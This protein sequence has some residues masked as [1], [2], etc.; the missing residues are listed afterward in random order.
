MSPLRKNIW[1]G[2]CAAALLLIGFMLG[3]RSQSGR[4]DGDLLSQVS[5]QGQAFEDHQ[6]LVK[7]RLEKTALENGIKT[8]G[9][10]AQACEANFST[11]TVLYEPGTAPSL[12][13]M[14]GLVDVQVPGLAGPAHAAWVIPAKIE[15]RVI[16]LQ[17]GLV[18]GYIDRDTKQIDGPYPPI[19]IA[20]GDKMTVAGWTAR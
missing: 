5:S 3:A 20:N 15:P 19:A 13:V 8:L 12:S 14:R 10:R 18:Y 1:L 7:L 11:Y 16:A 6:E 17:P 2:V 9:T 4:I